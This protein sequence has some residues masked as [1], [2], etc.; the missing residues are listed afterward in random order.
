M[1]VTKILKIGE[2]NTEERVIEEAVQILKKGG[3]VIIPTETVYGIVANA[4]D[5]RAVERLAAI[6]QRPKDKP[7]SLLVANKEAVEDLAQD[8]SAACY[9]LMD[10]FWPGPLTIILKSKDG[11]K[12]GL[13][14]PDH[15]LALKIAAQAG[16]PLVCP[17]ANLSGKPAPVDFAQAMQDLGGLVDLAIDAGKA[18][19]GLESTV[20]DGTLHP[21]QVL[22][23]GAIS[24][25]EIEQEAARKTV[26]FVCT[27][28]SCRSV[29]AEGL[30]KKLLRQKNRR[31]ITVIS[32]GVL[33]AFG[34][35]AT[36]ETKEVLRQDGIDVS[37]H[38]S[39]RITPLLAKKSDFILV[40]EKAQEERILALAPEVK[41]RLFLLKEFANSVRNYDILNKEKG[42]SNGA[43][44]KD[45]SLDIPDPIGTALDFY[46]Q[47]YA[48]IKEAVQRVAEII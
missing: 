48:V 43:K 4:M 1:P 31:D 32:A 40:M 45:N 34:L 14:M 18:K 35:G 44:I 8:I 19:L 30:L 27:G 3:L 26:L 6:K 2:A 22:R 24:K 29:M 41:N 25:E 37:G 11:N 7:F 21:L 38:R 46:S 33:N 5:Q 23:A 10:K 17:S 36:E 13:R 15:P 28:N 12:V 42:V 20:V 47:T 39:Q 16:M 9:R